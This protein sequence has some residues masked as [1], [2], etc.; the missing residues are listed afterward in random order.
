MTISGYDFK[1][2]CREIREGLNQVA[3]A[4]AAIAVALE[5][6]DS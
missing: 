2:G 1:D 4:L 6:K 3:K 5:K